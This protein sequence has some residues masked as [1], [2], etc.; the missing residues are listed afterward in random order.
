MIDEIDNS[1]KMQLR[2][3]KFAT[4][5]LIKLRARKKILLKSL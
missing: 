4:E 2:A 3:K 5:K 1:I